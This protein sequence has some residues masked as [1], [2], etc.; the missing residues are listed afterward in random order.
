MGTSARM[1]PQSK[2]TR[3]NFPLVPDEVTRRAIRRS[4]MENRARR[5]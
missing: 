4:G 5:L 3:L 1:Q 2:P